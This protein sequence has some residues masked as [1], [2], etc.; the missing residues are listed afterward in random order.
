MEEWKVFPVM[1]LGILGT[2]Q[3]MIKEFKIIIK[4]KKIYQEILP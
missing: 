2:K 4:K 3:T 1:F